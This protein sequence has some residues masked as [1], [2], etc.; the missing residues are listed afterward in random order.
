MFNYEILFRGA[1]GDGGNMVTSCHGIASIYFLA[2]RPAKRRE[3]VSQTHKYVN[4]CQILSCDNM[5]T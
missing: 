4:T 5:R 2:A 3:L 1:S